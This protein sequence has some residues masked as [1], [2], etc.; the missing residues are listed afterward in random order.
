[1][2]GEVPSIYVYV[3]AAIV[4]GSGLFVI[5]R[6]QKLRLNRIREIEGPRI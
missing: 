2:F 3:G 5:W 1:M 6:E 4:A